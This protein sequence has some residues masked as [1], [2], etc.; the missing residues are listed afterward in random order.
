MPETFKLQLPPMLGSKAITS[1]AGRAA[2]LEEALAKL[3]AETAGAVL[4]TLDEIA[5]PMNA[6]ELEKALMLTDLN[7]R[8]RQTVVSALKGFAIL[9][10]VPQ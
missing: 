2:R 10:V 1:G 7:Y 4:A 9:L 8:Q 3:P 5:R 6:R